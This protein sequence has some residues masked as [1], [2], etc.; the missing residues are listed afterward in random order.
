M[1]SSN[2]S[3]SL[4]ELAIRILSLISRKKSSTTPLSTSTTKTSYNSSSSGIRK[5]GGLQRPNGKLVGEGMGGGIRLRAKQASETSAASF[6]QKSQRLLSIL[7]SR[8]TTSTLV[9]AYFY[10]SSNQAVTTSIDNNKNNNNLNLNNNEKLSYYFSSIQ[11]QV[12]QQPAASIILPIQA[13]EQ[14]Q[15]MPPSLSYS[16]SS[17]PTLVYKNN[18]ELYSIFISMFTAAVFLIFIMWRWIRIKS[19]L[20]QALREQSEIERQQNDGNGA[21]SSSSSSSSSASPNPPSSLACNGYSMTPTRYDM[22]TY[23]LIER[24]FNWIF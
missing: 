10:L 4:N 13:G 12:V 21:T 17:S 1:D 15:P 16:F 6:R 2:D 18:N 20:R 9:P 23:R 14:A 11:D 5:I 22:N 8:T 24:L 7:A 3:R 19:D